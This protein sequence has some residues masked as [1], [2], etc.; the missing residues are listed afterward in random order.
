MVRGIH[1]VMLYFLF[2]YM[3]AAWCQ[4]LTVFGWFLEQHIWELPV[5]WPVLACWK[6]S[7]LFLSREMS[8]GDVDTLEP[9]LLEAGEANPLDRRVR[10]VADL[11]FLMLA[12]R[13]MAEKQKVDASSGCRRPAMLPSS[14]SS[15]L[16]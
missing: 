8:L 14:S 16:S 10:K 12:T 1:T 4:I 5:K 7:P 11:Q 9:E 2:V 13:R 6:S 15:R 3:L